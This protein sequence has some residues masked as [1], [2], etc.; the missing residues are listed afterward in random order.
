MWSSVP[1]DAGAGRYRLSPPSRWPP[2][3]PWSALLRALLLRCAP[4]HHRQLAAE[5]AGPTQGPLRPDGG[6]DAGKAGGDFGCDAVELGGPAGGACGI[7]GVAVAQVGSEAREERLAGPRVA[8]YTQQRAGVW[9][10]AQGGVVLC[11]GD[12]P[13]GRRHLPR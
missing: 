5:I 10:V 7:Y 3:T 6:E 2:A 9:R 1:S 13:H 12:L 11:G 8:A 4:A